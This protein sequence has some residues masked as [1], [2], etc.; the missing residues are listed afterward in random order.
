MLL[1]QAA[2][3][4]RVNCEYL[5]K[6]L[7]TVRF[8]ARQ[9]LALRGDGDEVDSNLQLLVLRGED[10]STMS[11]FLER[12]QLKY[13]SPEVQ[14]ELLSIMALQILRNVAANIQT[15]VHYTV[16]VDETTD[17]SNKEQVVLVLRW[18]DEALDVHEEFIGLYATSST[19]AESLVSII[20][21]TLLRMN[22]KI[23]HCRGQCYD[24]ASAMSGAKKGVA[25]ILTDADCRAPGSLHPLL[26]ARSQLRGE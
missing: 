11:K 13:T 25:K 23:E 4:K 20:K 3:E 2:S 7:S 8:L 5:L 16:M 9:G 10:Y 14:N 15:A 19:T 6:V 24:G 1:R 12:Q 26:R 22:L 18:V 21:D 17:Q